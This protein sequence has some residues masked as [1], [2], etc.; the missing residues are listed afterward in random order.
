VGIESKITWVT[1]WR[2]L[3]LAHDSRPDNIEIES[4][5]DFYVEE[6]VMEQRSP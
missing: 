5:S 3:F 4:F 1:F 6:N 2:S